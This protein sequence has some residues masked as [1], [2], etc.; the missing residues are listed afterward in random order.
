MPGRIGNFADVSALWNT[1]DWLRRGW[2]DLVL[3]F[4]AERQSRML[5]S[6]GIEKLDSR[7]L[8][9]L[10]A[11]VALLTMGWMLWWLRRGERERD[12]LLRAWH[13]LSTRYRRLGLSRDASEP[14]S[15]WALRVSKAR[16]G[17][18]DA[19]QSLAQRFSESRYAGAAATSHLI[20]D[21]DAFRP[22]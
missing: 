1:A 4:N 14:A 10:F 3:G 2:N 18:A 13:R 22:R 8:V 5:Q 6:F 17:D 15:E 21:L 7:T 16:P 20:R 9:L 19:L 11:L 12:A